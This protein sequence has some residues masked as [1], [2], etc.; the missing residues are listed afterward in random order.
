MDVTNG[1]KTLLVLG[2]TL[3]F[4]TAP[5][6]VFA[7]IEGANIKG[8]EGANVLGIEG[9]N[10][11]GIEGANV[12]GIEGAN[13]LGIEGA[14]VLGI[15]GANL[16]VGPVSAID[17]RNGTFSA[18][19]QVVLA[20]SQDLERIQLGR[21]VSVVGTIAG[22]GVI[23]ADKVSVSDFPYVAGATEVLVIGMPSK[24]DTLSGRATLGGLVVDFTAGMHG[25]NNVAG[26]TWGFK[27]TQPN[28]RGLMVADKFV[29]SD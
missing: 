21:L 24:V 5:I 14:N 27:G 12:A 4:V 9:A 7:S 23:Y 2:A 18:L 15:E 16:L 10:T 3:V 13:V 19:G 1:A 25:G 28:A 6:D 29:A 22:P 20:S 17:R 8:I 11:R 26:R